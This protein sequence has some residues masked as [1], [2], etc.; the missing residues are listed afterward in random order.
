MQ[1]TIVCKRIAFIRS[2]HI[3]AWYETACVE[4]RISSLIQKLYRE[5]FILNG[6]PLF[7][8][9][10]IENGNDSNSKD[11]KRTEHCSWQSLG[12]LKISWLWIDLFTRDR[13]RFFFFFAK[14]NLFHSFLSSILFFLFCFV[15]IFGYSS[16][17]IP[18]WISKFYFFCLLFPLFG[19]F[20]AILPLTVVGPF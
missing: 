3:V 20:S 6:K 2:Y 13:E 8:V 15:V 1:G 4:N 18:L 17:S 19:C 5:A 11:K 7:L 12:S 14:A 10:D 16:S 9:M